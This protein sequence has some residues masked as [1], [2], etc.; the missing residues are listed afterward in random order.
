MIV[1]INETQFCISKPNIPPSTEM[2]NDDSVATNSGD[3]ANSTR[4]SSISY[5]SVLIF[6]KKKKKSSNVLDTTSTDPEKILNKA[7]IDFEFRFVAS[8]LEKKC[9]EYE[10]ITDTTINNNTANE[11]RKHD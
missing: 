9:H 8:E 10:R 6:L 11:T 7:S 3:K 1:A 5:T 2:L 4:T